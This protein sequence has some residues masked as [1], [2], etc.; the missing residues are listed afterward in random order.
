MLPYIIV[1]S[2]KIITFH[3]LIANWESLKK[4]NFSRIRPLFCFPRNI[5]P[6]F[7]GGRF[8]RPQTWL[9]FSLTSYSAE[10]SASWQ[11]KGWPLAA[12]DPVPDGA[13]EVDV[14]P[15]PG[16]VVEA[17]VHVDVAAFVHVSGTLCTFVHQVHLQ[18]EKESFSI[19]SLFS[20]STPNH[21]TKQP[22]N[23]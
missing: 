14:V 5:Q 1:K 23:Y 10:F 8:V 19:Y 2:A 22:Y 6:Q 12:R 7:F 18:R 15:V 11:Q 13:A 21:P 20:Q 9:F 4:L 3:A 17:A 16:V